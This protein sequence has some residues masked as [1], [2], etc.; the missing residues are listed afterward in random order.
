MAGKT[1][2]DVIRHDNGDVWGR[3]TNWYT[4]YCPNCEHPVERL[5]EERLDRCEVCNGQFK[6]PPIPLEKT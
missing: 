1:A 3:G 4:F 5:D 2:P 6:W